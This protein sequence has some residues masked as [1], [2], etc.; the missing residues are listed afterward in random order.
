M[1]IPNG[2]VHDTPAASPSVAE[3]V[4]ARDPSRSIKCIK[5][6]Y[7]P[8]TDSSLSSSEKRKAKPKYKEFG[9]VCESDTLILWGERHL[10]YELIG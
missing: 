1:P 2:L 10:D 5:C 3:R 8:L 9:L 7:D 6:T 4:P